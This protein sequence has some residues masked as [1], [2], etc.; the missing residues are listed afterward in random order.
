MTLIFVAGASDRLF[1]QFGI[2]YTS[3]VHIFRALALVTPPVAF[4]M[5]K[6][7]CNQLRRTQVRPG[8]SGPSRR[9][10]RRDDGGFDAR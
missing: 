10:R 8:L 2:A 3:Q 7:A 5:A 4:V 9:L 6:I 1:Y